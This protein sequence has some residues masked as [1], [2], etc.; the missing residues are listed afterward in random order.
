MPLPITDPALPFFADH[1]RELA[2]AA[3]AWA[4]VHLAQQP[5]IEDVDASC[6]ALARQLGAAGWLQWCVPPANEEGKTPPLDARAICLLRETFAWHSSLAD[7]VFAMQGLGAGA[8]SLFGDAAQRARYLLGVASGELLA[9]FALSE[10]GAGSDAAA[11]ACRA[12]RLADGSWQ[13]DGEKTWVSNG[14]I[15]DFYI[16]FARTEEEEEEE[17]APERSSA[18]ISAFIVDADSPG[19]AVAERIL[20]LSPHPLA[21]L[22]FSACQVPASQLL[23]SPGEGFRIAMATLD[24]F[25]ISVAAAALG[26]ARRAAHEALRHVQERRMFG[27][28]L[29]D[30]QITQAKLADMATAIDAAALLTYRAAWQ[31]DQGGTKMQTT[32]TA[33]MAKLFATEEAQRV[34]D[35]AVQLFGGRGITQG[36]VVEALYRDI[37]ALRIY[38]G[39]SEV[40]KLVIARETLQAFKDSGNLP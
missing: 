15:A 35:A 3:A 22:E 38:E 9:A 11:L 26:L 4:T 33:A 12:T 28:R 2:P 37:R 40:Q 32:R 31:R 18:G 10:P 25:R 23:G 14:G 7:F 1:H 17:E 36:E 30:M 8:I 19:L 16:V 39:A 20:T 13:L 29:A 21:R 5:Q 34:I 6:R 24:M 27:Q